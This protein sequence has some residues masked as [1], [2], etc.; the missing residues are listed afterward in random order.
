MDDRGGMGC[1]VA[2]LAVVPSGGQVVYKGLSLANRRIIY[3]LISLDHLLRDH[4]LALVRDAVFVK[5]LQPKLEALSE[6]MQA[7]LRRIAYSI[8]RATKDGRRTA[9]S[10]PH[11]FAL[12]GSI[13]ELQASLA[14][15]ARLPHVAAS[16][17]FTHSVAFVQLLIETAQRVDGLQRAADN[18]GVDAEFRELNKSRH[19]TS[20]SVR[21]SNNSFTRSSSNS[22][23][24]MPR[25]EGSK[26]RVELS[27]HEAE[28]AAPL[29]QV[30]SREKVA[31]HE[32]PPPREVAHRI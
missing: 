23:E 21:L 28:G 8:A 29:R 19:M 31:P 30:V 11:A 3:G 10:P 12:D 4:D 20:S 17:H 7:I 14:E 16:A 1:A 9:R 25:R 24:D 5:M 18:M 2:H 26:S 15:Y 13:A 32:E 22:V 6:I 27:S